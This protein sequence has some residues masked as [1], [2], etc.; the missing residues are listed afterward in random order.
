MQD[1]IVKIEHLS[2]KYTSSWAIRDINIEIN[3]TGIVGLLGSNGAGKSTTMNILCGSLNQTEGNVYI[4]GIDVREKPEE[5]KKQIGFLPQTPPLYMDLTVDEYLIY[6]AELRLM[7][8][9]KIR[10]ALAD[11]KERCG[12]THFSQRLIGNLSGGYRQRVGIAQAIIHRPK[13]VV[14]DEPTNGLDP[15]Q[16]IEVRALIK[17]IAADRAVIFSSHVLTEVQM[18]CKEIKM[19]EGGRIVFSDT[20]DAF[21]NYVAPHSILVRLENPPPA[22]ELMKITGVTSVDFLTERQVRVYFSGDQE[23]AERLVEASVRYSW[24]LREIN[25][26]KSALDEIFKQLS[27]RSSIN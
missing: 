25:L 9:D 3:Q 23:I 24:R 11:A 4:N 13:L 19:I 2:H 17:E 26:D 7:P 5:A 10:P 22:E 12:I 27:T 21:N 16:I 15:N 6:C 14:L 20:M 18:L 1:A 8:K